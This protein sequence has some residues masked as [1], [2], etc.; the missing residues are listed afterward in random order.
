MEL[1]LLILGDTGWGDEMLRAS[2]VTLMVSL[3]AMSI[4]LFISIFGT[5]SKLS[6]KFYLRLLGDVYSTIVRGIPELLVI[7]LL[8]FGGSSAVMS[9]A[10]LFGYNGYI[11]LNA[12]VIG[13]IAVGAIS[14]AYSTEVIR[15]AFLAIPRGQID[16]AK[17]VGM[18][19]FIM[20]TRILIPQILRYALPGL[21]NVWQLTL[22]DTALIMVTGLV[23]IM[24]QS[25]IA[26]GSTYSPFTFYVTAALLYLILTT[27]SNTI[28]NSAEN[29]ANKGV[30]RA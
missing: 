12:F 21:G 27:V 24:R 7:Y 25:H 17:S 9:I 16:A 11:E 1:D 8:F 23:E 2:L 5:L 18:N 30:R 20:F 15:G 14:G 19:K 4:G 3:A 26:S 28:F 13:S 6:N 29:W 10:K 22:K